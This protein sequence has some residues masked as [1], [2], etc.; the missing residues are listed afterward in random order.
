MAWRNPA[1]YPFSTSSI[2]LNAP[3]ESGV[4]ALF[5]KTTWVYVGESRNIRAQLMGH[6][7]GDIAC[8]AMFPSLTFSYELL[9]PLI[10][11]WR[12]SEVISELRPVCNTRL[13]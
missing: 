3:H 2:L 11:P 6:L 1:S 4:Y 9:L 5:N 12:L 8:I 7:N 10:C 13:D